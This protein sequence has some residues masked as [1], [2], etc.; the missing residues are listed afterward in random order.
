MNDY[1]YNYLMVL[2]RICQKIEK[3]QTTK[4]KNPAKRIYTTPKPIQGKSYKQRCL[5][6]SPI[7]KLLIKIIIC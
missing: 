4:K 5:T 6:L 2:Y 7:R 3:S 1:I